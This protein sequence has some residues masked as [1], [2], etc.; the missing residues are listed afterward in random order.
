LKGNREKGWGILWP[1]GMHSV[2]DETLKAWP[3]NTGFIPDG[4]E[5]EEKIISPSNKPFEVYLVDSCNIALAY[6]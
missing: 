1:N 6:I 5:L 3:P 4:H 2:T